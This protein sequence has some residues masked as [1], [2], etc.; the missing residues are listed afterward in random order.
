MRALAVM[1]VGAIVASC[2][3]A[4]TPAPTATGR[5]AAPTSQPSFLSVRLTDVRTGEQFTLGGFPGKVVLGIAM[6]VW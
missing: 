5:A 3:G 2:G 6:A 1:V 4:A